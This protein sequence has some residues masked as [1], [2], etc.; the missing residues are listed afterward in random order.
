MNRGNIGAYPPRVSVKGKIYSGFANHCCNVFG[1]GG[2]KWKAFK[3]SKAYKVNK[4]PL[5]PSTIKVKSN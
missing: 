5:R 2:V 4:E 1:D 3:T